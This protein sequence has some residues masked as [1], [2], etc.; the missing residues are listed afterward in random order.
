M[1]EV[2]RDGKRAYAA[3]RVLATYSKEELEEAIRPHGAVD[4]Y[5]ND[6]GGGCGC[7]C[8]CGCGAG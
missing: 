8:G 1:D 3:P 5:T 4:S 7:G 6:G 2:T